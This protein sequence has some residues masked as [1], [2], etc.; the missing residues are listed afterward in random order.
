MLINKNVPL[1]GQISVPNDKSIVH[2]AFFTAAIADGDSFIRIPNCGFDCLA[3]IHCFR[4]LGVSITMCKEGYKVQGVGMHGLQ[5]FRGK[6]DCNNSG[7]TARILLGL[8]SGQ[9]FSSSITGDSS[10]IKR[11]MARVVDPLEQMGEIGRASCR[12]RV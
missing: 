12:E 1:R 6:L 4:N 7:T 8:L 2:R 5:K 10:L 3:T 11:P 9:S